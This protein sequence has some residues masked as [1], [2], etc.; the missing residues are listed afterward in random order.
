MSMVECVCIKILPFF[1][2]STTQELFP[3]CSEQNVAKFL[4]PDSSAVGIAEMTP[5]H[6]T[7]VKPQDLDMTEA[8]C[9]MFRNSWA[10]LC[11][12]TPLLIRSHCQRRV[13]ECDDQANE[14][15]CVHPSLDMEERLQTHLVVSLYGGTENSL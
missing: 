2:S 3:Q 4:V 12:R 1:I 9:G 10:Q 7:L 6:L 15:L 8:S 14:G 11:N 13:E 5:Y